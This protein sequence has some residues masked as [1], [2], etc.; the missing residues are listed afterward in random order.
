[1]SETLTAP[2]DTAGD[3]ETD[4]RFAGMEFETDRQERESA[5]PQDDAG[6]S[7]E[8]KQDEQSSGQKNTGT[9]ARLQKKFD[10]MTF[11]LREAER[12][13]AA[14]RE[15][16][17]PEPAPRTERQI[18]Q[19]T[20]GR[21]ERESHEAREI[22]TFNQT[23]RTLAEAV[24][25]AYGNDAITASTHTLEREVGLDFSNAEHRQLVTDIAELPNAAAVYRGL[26]DDLDKADEIFN[27]APR[28]QYAMLQEFARSLDKAAPPPAPAQRAMPAPVSQAPRPVARPPASAR[29]SSRTG[30]ED[31]S[32]MEDFVAAREKR[33]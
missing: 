9:P 16:A 33:R 18:E 20:R 26:A 8:E 5:L 1:M 2:A 13:A 17:E 32:S 23:A 10:R 11:E 12:Q 24:G 21:V 3:A 14:A 6:Q 29:A 25:A 28:R 4:D 31:E 7:E 30:Y 15:E 27:A 22:E 19:E